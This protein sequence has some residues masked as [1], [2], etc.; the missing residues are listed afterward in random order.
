M[1]FPVCLKKVLTVLL[2]LALLL[3]LAPQ[4][5]A[6]DHDQRAAEPNLNVVDEAALQG[7][8]DGL[9][10]ERQLNADNISVGYCYTATGETW[11]YRPDD[12][13]YAASLY[14]VPLSMLFAE[15]EKAGELT[16]ESD[17][18]GVTLGYAEEVVLVNS[19]NDYAHVMM[20]YLGGDKTSRE[21]YQSYSSMPSEDFIQDY[22]D[23]A[24]F[25]V[26]FMTDVMKTLYYE[27]DRFPHIIDLLKQA[28]PG[29]WFR[30]NEDQGYEIAQKYGSYNEY[31]RNLYNNTCG[32]VYTPQPFLL[33]V[34]SRNIGDAQQF[35][36][37]L[38]R[39]M[40]DY[41]VGLDGALEQARQQAALAPEQPAET[42]APVQTEETAPVQEDPAGLEQTEPV[43]TPAPEEPEK[44]GLG[45]TLLIVAAA[46]VLA[47]L[48]LTAV[49][50]ILR[51]RRA[52]EDA[53]EADWDDEDDEPE[54]EPV[55]RPQPAPQAEWEP[56]PAPKPAKA[57]TRRGG[58]TPKH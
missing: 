43:Q 57:R 35:I 25:S 34:L 37:D 14:K 39:K 12:W 21:L 3:P 24:Y 30:K 2:A 41:T 15:K 48:I 16:Q 22:Y 31:N 45:R 42:E 7:I 26:R 29:E 18:S 10:Q 32:I 19:N 52:S 50:L 38:E 54:D 1:R 11:Y 27:Q 49:L 53:W 23:Y 6:L 36:A 44:G 5:L 4:A 8:V 51:R 46:V 47:A 33:V 28:Q 17:I 40:A 13:Y 9:I 56:E 20:N 55:Y 58:Y